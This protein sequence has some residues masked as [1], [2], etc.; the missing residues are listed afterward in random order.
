LDRPGQFLRMGWLIDRSAGTVRSRRPITNWRP[1]IDANYKFRF[2]LEWLF[3]PVRR[4]KPSLLQGTLDAAITRMSNFS[5]QNFIFC[6]LPRNIRIIS[7]FWMGR[8][9]PHI[10]RCR[11]M[12][13]YLFRR[14]EAARSRCQCK[15]NGLEGELSKLVVG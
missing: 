9:S 13:W 7:H 14:R 15:F 1:R 5:P 10:G 6:C 3:P 12:E 2:V 11:W 8:F 4:A